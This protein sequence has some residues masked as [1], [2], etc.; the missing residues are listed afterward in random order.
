MSKPTLRL[1][2]RDF[3]DKLPR[4]HSEFDFLRAEYERD[5][6][7]SKREPRR[8]GGVRSVNHRNGEIEVTTFDEKT[9]RGEAARKYLAEIAARLN[10]Q[11]RQV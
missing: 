9:Y 7:V 1:R 8:T 5:F 6:Q 4:N 3:E 11:E 10:I 2:P